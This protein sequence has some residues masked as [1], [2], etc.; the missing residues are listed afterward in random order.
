MICNI[1]NPLSLMKEQKSIPKHKLARAASLVQTGAVIGANFAKYHAQKAL[2]G[3]ADREALDKA[4]AAATYDTFSKLKGSPLKVAQMLS[5]DKNILPSAYSSEFQK[6]YYSAPPLSYPLVLKT[7]K[8]E[9]GKAP[10]DIFDE[11]SRQAVAGAS[12]GQVHKAR[13]GD[14][15]YAVKVQYPGVADS[16]KSDLKLVKP[17]AMRLFDLDAQALDPYLQEV[18]ARLLEETDYELELRRSIDLANRSSELPFVQ[19]PRYH[20]ELSGPR[21]ITMDWVDG[22]P[23][24]KYIATN[25]PQEERNRIG[26]ALWNFI[27]HQVH[28]LRQFHAD[29]HPGNFLVHQGELWVLDFGCVKVLDNDFYH[30][31]FALMDDVRVDNP[32][33]FEQMLEQLDLLRPGDT[34]RIRRKLAEV[35]YQSVKI[36]SRPY[37]EEV[38]DFGDESYVRSIYEFSEQTRKD[39]ELEKITSSRGNAHAIYLNR[40]FYGLY[41]LAASLCARIEARLPDHLTRK[42]TPAA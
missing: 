19:F 1:A 5:I 40:A 28:E 36:L 16:L 3:K 22:L 34:P 42:A 29:P 37:R 6:S 31:Y 24:D 23:L 27:H 32:V 10:T 30:Q 26:Q 38:F 33:D 14:R 9:V 35:Y 12:I 15:Y 7:F 39:K 11:F 17:F 20:P 2:T 13:I 25:P 4:N 8:R 41:N 18:E 21:I